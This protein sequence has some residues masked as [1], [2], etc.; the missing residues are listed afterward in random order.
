MLFEV[1]RDNTQFIG[2]VTN[3]KSDREHEHAEENKAGVITKLL[4]GQGAQV[5]VAKRFG[6]NINR[7]KSKFVCVVVKEGNIVENLEIVRQKFQLMKS[8]WEKGE[9]RGIVN[10]KRVE[11]PGIPG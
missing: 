7:M 6:G 5:L 1:S 9:T 4:K 10:F 11:S 3:I 8:E 2:A